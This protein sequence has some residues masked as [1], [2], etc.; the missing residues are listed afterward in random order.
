MWTQSL[1]SS[2]FTTSHGKPCYNTQAAS[3]HYTSAPLPVGGSEI[4]VNSRALL[5]DSGWN[6]QTRFE[7]LCATYLP[8]CR[9][10]R[11]RQQARTPVWYAGG[12]KRDYTITYF[13]GCLVSFLR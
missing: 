1:A 13:I 7:H 9:A 6:R 8:T 11:L 10:G 2:A 3:A 4:G 12:S 5:R